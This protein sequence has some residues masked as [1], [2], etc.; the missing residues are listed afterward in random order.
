MKIKAMK[1]IYSSVLI[2]AAFTFCS[3]GVNEYSDKVNILDLSLNKK[4]LKRKADIQVNF[5]LIDVNGKVSTEFNEGENFTFSLLLENKSD[6]TLFL[7]NSFLMDGND[8][9]AVY[10]HDGHL[11]GQPFIYGGSKIVSSNA[12]PFYGN[13]RTF[14][15]SVPWKDNRPSWTALH[16]TFRGL[17]QEGLPAGKYYTIFKHRFCFDRSSDRPSLCLQPLNIRIDFEVKK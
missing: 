2:I 8:F 1:V 6:D 13:Q 11:V 7:D 14:T 4:S 10:T 16:H 5:N 12:F 15:L 17:N 9:C 3:W